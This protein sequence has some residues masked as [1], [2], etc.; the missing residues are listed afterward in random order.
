MYGAVDL[1]VVGW[2]GDATSL[3]AVSTCSNLVQMQQ[4]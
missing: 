4:C 1:L 3:S 2:F